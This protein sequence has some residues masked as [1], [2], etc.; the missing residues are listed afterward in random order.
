M[1]EKES[2]RCAGK[3]CQ[4]E[5][6]EV[7]PILLAEGRILDQC[8]DDERDERNVGADEADQQDT[9]RVAGG[10]FSLLKRR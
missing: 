4:Q 6:E 1:D 3:R 2:D 10:R 9:T 5:H 7:C 8:P